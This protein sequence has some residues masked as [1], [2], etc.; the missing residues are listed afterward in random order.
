M[1]RK[2]F[3]GRY[4]DGIKSFWK[5]VSHEMKAQGI[6]WAMIDNALEMKQGS[7]ASLMS[8]GTLVSIGI[9][10]RLADVLNVSIDEL[11]FGKRKN[12]IGLDDSIR[13]KQIYED[14]R[15]YSE[16]GRYN[17]GE[18]VVDLPKPGKSIYYD[19]DLSKGLVEGRFISPAISISIEDTLVAAKRM[20]EKASLVLCMANRRNPEYGAENGLNT[21][22]AHLIRSSNYY[23]TL[24]D[25]KDKAYPI[26]RKYGGIYSP[27]VTVFRDSE[28]KPYDLMKE[29]FSISIVAVP[30]LYKP[31]FKEGQYSDADRTQME[32]K[33]RTIL[34]IAIRQKHDTLILSAFGC[35]ASGNPP[36]LVA[37]L[38][39]EALEEP[40]YSTN[41][42][43][44]VFAINDSETAETFRRVLLSK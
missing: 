16:E 32:L 35:G 11:W 12:S 13:L 23:L 14:T 38:F 2:K 6:S 4:D 39:K 21:Q 41:F 9:A 10:A 36:E 34:N 27:S 3:D 5:N 29:P 42:R 19:H 43:E 17:I 8:H 24:L 7:S 37:R 18:S 20:K 25:I 26:N 22:E 33:V 44:I 40:V 28:R 15:K 31:I 1:T 30:A